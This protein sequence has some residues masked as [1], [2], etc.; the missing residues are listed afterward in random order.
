[1]LTNYY[2]YLKKLNL[3]IIKKPENTSSQN[4]VNFSHLFLF[5]MAKKN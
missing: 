1:M 5:K 4:V 3:K 2:H